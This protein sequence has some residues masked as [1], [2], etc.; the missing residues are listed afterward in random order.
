MD[1]RRKLIRK[2]TEEYFKVRRR[3]RCDFFAVYNER[4]NA[5]LGHLV[6]VTS[7][8][9]MI[10]SGSP[11]DVSVLYDIRIDL[12]EKVDGRES[13]NVYARPIWTGPAP[14]DGFHHTGF[15]FVRINPAEIK[16]LARLF[17][18]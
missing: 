2:P 7:E 11:V 14:E 10:V 9:M 18:E 4:D 16:I 13:I 5:L 3:R 1:E 17:G 8:G 12:P 6:D 15:Q